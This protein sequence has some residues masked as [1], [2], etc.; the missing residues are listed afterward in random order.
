MGVGVT[1]GERP[2]APEAVA[3][4]HE[5]T[6]EQADENLIIRRRVNTVASVTARLGEH[7]H[8]ETLLV[9]GKDGT[10]P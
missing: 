9:Q 8:L 1:V 7:S 2:A 3:Y 4:I 5:V 10:D 6:V